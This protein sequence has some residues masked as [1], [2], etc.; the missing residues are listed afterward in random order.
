MIE[1][2]FNPVEES[3]ADF[4]STLKDSIKSWDY[5][6]NWDKVFSNTKQIE[7]DLNILNYLLGKDNFEQAFR[8]L[9]TQH[10][11]LV[12][13]IPSLIVRDGS[14]SMKF[15]ISDGSISSTDRLDEIPTV[16]ISIKNSL[17]M[18]CVI[19]KLINN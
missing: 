7:I 10:P 14:K 4:Y 3:F 5:F 2:G 17:E 11:H 9:F 18:C 13:T 16:S 19:I 1:D 12:R 15:E 6:V 8:D